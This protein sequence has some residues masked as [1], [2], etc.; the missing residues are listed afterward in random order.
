M[1]YAFFAVRAF[2]PSVPR[3][4]LVPAA[5][6]PGLRVTEPSTF[7][8]APSTLSLT[9]A[10]L[11][12]WVA[13]ALFFTP[14]PVALFLVAVFVAGLRAVVVLRLRSGVVETVGTT[15]GFEWPVAARVDA[16]AVVCCLLKFV[17]FRS[18]S[19]QLLDRVYHNKRSVASRS[20]G[21]RGP[22]RAGMCREKKEKVVELSGRGRLYTCD[23]ESVI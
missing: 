14:A 13:G 18:G 9:L 8:R 20:C 16:I 22:A 19:W 3:I 5:F 12:W 11:L 21:G 15:R 6:L 23:Q 1:I 17:Y 10:F 2:L 4:F 7:S